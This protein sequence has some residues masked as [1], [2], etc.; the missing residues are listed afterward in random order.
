M[1]RHANTATATLEIELDREALEGA[2][3]SAE[4]QHATYCAP[5]RR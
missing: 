1:Y 4:G 3:T 5:H 2:A